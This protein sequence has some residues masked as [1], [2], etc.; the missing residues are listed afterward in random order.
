MGFLDQLVCKLLTKCVHAVILDTTLLPI[1]GEAAP[2]LSLL[3]EASLLWTTQGPHV[4]DSVTS[5]GQEGSAWFG[6]CFV[7]SDVP[8]SQHLR[9]SISAKRVEAVAKAVL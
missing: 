4:S 1:L 2:V 6:G 5:K 8:L 9:D 7:A 3:R